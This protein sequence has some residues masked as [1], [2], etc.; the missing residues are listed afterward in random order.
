MHRIYL[1]AI[2]ISICDHMEKK[3]RAVKMTVA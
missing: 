1:E 2:R 3:N